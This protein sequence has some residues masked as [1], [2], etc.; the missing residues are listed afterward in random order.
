MTGHTPQ[1]TLQVNVDP[2]N[3]GQYFGCCGLLELSHRIWGSAEGWFEEGQFRVVTG[4]SLADL[5]S[6][7][8][9]A[10]LKQVDSDDD[11]SSPIEIEAPFELRLDWWADERAGGKSLK[12]WAGSMRSVRIARAMQAALRQSRFHTEQLFE[13]GTVVYD[14]SEPDKKVEP[15][16]FDARRGM[17]AQSLDIGFAP[18]AFQMTT[19]AYPAVEFLCLVGLQRCRPTPIGNRRTFDY[20]TWSIPVDVC[21]VPAAACGLLADSNAKCYRFTNAFRT[22][23][24]KHKSFL[25]ATPIGDPR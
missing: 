13:Q 4:G 9:S 22:D 15:Y 20:W 23:Q 8:G 1:S 18:D 5:I 10:G 11:F 14:P 21:V 7:I 6:A 25:P 12:V 17:N 19:I 24:K 16:Y 3:P 2:T